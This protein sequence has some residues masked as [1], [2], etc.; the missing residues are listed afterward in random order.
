MYPH[1]APGAPRATGSMPQASA[2]E[3][4]TPIAHG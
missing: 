2:P 3:S 1:L 4:V